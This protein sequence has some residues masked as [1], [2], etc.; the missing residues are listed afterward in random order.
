[1]DLSWWELT[2][3]IDANNIEFDDLSDTL[4]EIG[5]L[6]TTSEA[7]Y[8]TTPDVDCELALGQT[9]KWSSIKVVTLFDKNIDINIDTIK[10]QIIKTLSLPLNSI[11]TTN[12]V[13]EQ[14]WQ[15]NFRQEFK[16]Q[17]FG[18]LWV[19]P[20]WHDKPTDNKTIM[21]LD[22]GLA[23]GTGSHP[24]TKLCLEWLAHQPLKNMTIID[25][26]C[27]SGILA[28][29]AC[30]LGAKKVFAIDHDNQALIATQENASMNNIPKEQ[31]HTLSGVEEINSLNINADILIAN[32]LAEPLMNL[33]KTFIQLLKNSGK[34]AMSGILI[35][36]QERL[37]NYYSPIL[38]DLNVK[39]H[40]DW[41]LVTGNK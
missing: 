22:P 24:T 33:S 32:I 41:C 1:M 17:Q 39:S 9:P 16:P 18:R 4:A 10:S 5:A 30:I 2:F 25:F 8:K 13:H 23:F 7:A 14:D 19:Y 37:I 36:Q 27:G 31:L 6:S 40:D 15:E 26:G 29:A 11:I 3:T 12:T 28:I 21:T 20:S 35:N 34:L 38:K